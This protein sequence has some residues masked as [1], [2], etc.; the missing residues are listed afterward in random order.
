MRENKSTIAR[1]EAKLETLRE[2][3]LRSD[4]LRVAVGVTMW[5]KVPGGIF[6]RYI[7]FEAVLIAPE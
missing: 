1:N 4:A 3:A 2:P 6:G 7:N 5:A